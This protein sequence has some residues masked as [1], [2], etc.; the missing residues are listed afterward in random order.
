[1][2]V[3]NRFMRLIHENGFYVTGTHAIAFSLGKIRNVMIA[4]KLRVRKINIGPRA[5]LR[6]L[7]SIQMGEDFSAA[8]GLWLEAVTQYNEQTFSPKIVIGQHVRISRFVHI[9]ATHLV[10]IGDDVLIGSNALI[11]DHNHG[12]YSTRH[13]SPKT[14]PSLR[15]LDHDRKIEIGNNVWLGDGV[16]VTPGSS[17]G[18]GSVIGAHSVVHGS[19]PAFSIA[20]GIPATVRKTYDFDIQHWSESK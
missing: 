8:E 18:E 15:L 12:Q 14:A 4:R 1:M 13:C 19:I 3:L 5:F 6:G 2:Q 11:I 20:A 17:I 16:I 7:S 10:T 9:A